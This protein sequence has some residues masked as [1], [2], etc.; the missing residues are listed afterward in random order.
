MIEVK[1]LIKD[2]W[3]IKSKSVWSGVLLIVYAII[4][5]VLYGNLDPQKILLGLGIIGLRDA[6]HKNKTE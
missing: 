5:Y 1:K 2:K 4:E 3:Y 6:I